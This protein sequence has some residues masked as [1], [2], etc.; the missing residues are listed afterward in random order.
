MCEKVQIEDETRYL[1]RMTCFKGLVCNL[2]TKD[3]D[4]LAKRQL[5]Q[6][7]ILFYKKEHSS[8]KKSVESL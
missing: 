3:S 4:N 8:A 1:S 2:T 7:I 5:W 6:L